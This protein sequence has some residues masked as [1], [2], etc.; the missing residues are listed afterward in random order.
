MLLPLNEQV[1]R[2]RTE[3]ERRA[4]S[5]S[6]RD[7]IV[8]SV[9]SLKQAPYGPQTATQLRVEVEKSESLTFDPGHSAQLEAIDF[10]QN[11]ALS[12]GRNEDWK[13][14]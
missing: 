9:N 5:Q 11:E 2:I 8:S 6:T 1:W 4:S 14:W 7:L 13:Y 10:W 12:F 3:L